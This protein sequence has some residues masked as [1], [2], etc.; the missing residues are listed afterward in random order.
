MPDGLPKL[1]HAKSDNG[2]EWCRKGGVSGRE[3]PSDLGA[4]KQI[5]FQQQIFRPGFQPNVNNFFTPNL[6]LL[7]QL[8]PPESILPLPRRRSAMKNE[9]D[10]KIRHAK[11]KLR[12]VAEVT[13]L[14]K[15]RASIK[16]Q[17]HQLSN[18]LDEKKH[19]W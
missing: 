1:N 5:T 15:Q 12:R 14:Q 6:N 4:L 17:L 7:V 13:W 10:V 16:V 11:A 8:L 3:S 19:H 2:L 18:I 9:E